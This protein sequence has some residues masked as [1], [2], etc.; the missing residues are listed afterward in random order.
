MPLG[1]KIMI[2][3][4]CNAIVV[5]YASCRQSVKSQSV[6]SHAACL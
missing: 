6:N 5:S 4:A 1:A 3:C 2:M